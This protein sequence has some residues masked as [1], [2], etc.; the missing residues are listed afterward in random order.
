[1]S[2]P[3]ALAGVRVLVAD[4]HV[5]IR[6]VVSQTLG[7]LG[8]QVDGAPEGGAAMA[9]LYSAGYDVFLTDLH[10]PGTDG[11]GLIEVA[12]TLH[13]SMPVIVITGFPHGE[14]A[15]AAIEAGAAQLLAKP[16]DLA[17]LSR[18]VQEVLAAPEDSAPG[19]ERVTW[20][21]E[22]EGIVRR[23]DRESLPDR[24][25]ALCVAAWGAADPRLAEEIRAALAEAHPPLR[26]RATAESRTL[27]LWRTGETFPRLVR[28]R[29]DE[30]GSAA[31]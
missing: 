31:A 3:G 20:W 16:F 10:M 8:A 23:R 12:Q 25:A 19:P 2:A 14:R 9:M 22:A 28:S 30:G 4:D 7:A 18:A 26:I 1:M 15:R 27:T 24:V 11:V 5:A 17:A 13:P 21:L 6:D 29:P